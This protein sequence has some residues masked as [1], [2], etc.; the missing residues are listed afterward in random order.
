[1]RNNTGLAGHFRFFC[2]AGH[3][4][5]KQRDLTMRD[6]CIMSRLSR[7]KALQNRHSRVSTGAGTKRDIAGHLSGPVA[8][9]DGTPPYRG[10]PHV[11]AG[12]YHILNEAFNN[13]T[14]GICY[15]EILHTGTAVAN[16][17]R[18]KEISG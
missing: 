17:E 4:A 15:A 9:R 11:P 7:Q 1:M 5:I 18:C 12:E 8:G 2:P 16:A 14:R 6:T 10:V 13:G 3:A